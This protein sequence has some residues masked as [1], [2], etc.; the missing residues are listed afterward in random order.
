ML[1][2]K[3]HIDALCAPMEIDYLHKAGPSK[4][5][6]QKG[7]MEWTGEDVRFCMAAAGQDRP[8]EFSCEPGAGGL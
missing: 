1:D 4:G 8:A 7:I 3:L 5:R 2:A 6:V